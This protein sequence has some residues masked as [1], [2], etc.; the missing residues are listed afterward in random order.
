MPG[1]GDGEH[2]ESVLFGDGDGDDSSYMVVVGNVSPPLAKL[3]L[4]N[5]VDDKLDL[6]KEIW[7]GGT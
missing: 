3:A 6:C 1:D 2:V 4:C 5:V 7:L